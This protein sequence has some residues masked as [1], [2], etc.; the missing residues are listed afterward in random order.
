MSRHAPGH[1]MNRKVHLHS[2]GFKQVGQVLDG[3]LGLRDR[4]SVSGG[5]HHPPGTVQ[6]HRHFFG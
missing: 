2:L 5:D 1:G 3:V 4:H 6:Q